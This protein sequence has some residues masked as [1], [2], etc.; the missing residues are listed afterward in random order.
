MFLE[1]TRGRKGAGP[2]KGHPTISYVNTGSIISF[3]RLSSRAYISFPTHTL[4]FVALVTGTLKVAS[5]QKI[6]S[7]CPV[8]LIQYFG[9]D[10]KGKAAG[11]FTLSYIFI[12]VKNRRD[13]TPL[14]FSKN[15]VDTV[16]IAKCICTE[17]G[18]PNIKMH[19]FS[20]A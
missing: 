19:C 11:Y 12:F 8:V 20:M 10:I 5:G 4:I 18:K 1:P 7:H 3:T 15:I 14:T 2:E 6:W 9:C 16:C 13:F 17:E